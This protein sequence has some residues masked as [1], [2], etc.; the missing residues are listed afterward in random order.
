MLA[1]VTAA[2]A[3]RLPPEPAP[4]VD[5]RVYLRGVSWQ[6]YE[7]LLAWR[8]DRSGVRMT[9]LEG[10]LEL[11]SPA[12]EH[13]TQKKTLA[14]LLEAWAEETDTPL[15]GAGSW[16]V[17]DEEAER[18]AEPDECYVLG[19]FEGRTAPD[20]AIE[21]VW[22]SG[23][24]DKLEVWRKLGAREVWFWM[25]GVLSFHVLRG[26]RYARS[27]RSQ[28]L[29]KLDPA[30]IIRCMGAPSQTEAVKELRRSLRAAPRKRRRS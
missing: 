16:T 19:S 25:H 22:T 29:P 17:K 6:A 26:R 7:A 2:L 1:P 8:G 3:L 9:Y 30:L 23:G 5:Q 24:L 14:R 13:E 20:I 11:M 15:E 10:T 28:I 21:V 4:D 27:E 18:G 12:R